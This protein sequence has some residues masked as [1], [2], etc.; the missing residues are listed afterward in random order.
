MTLNSKLLVAVCVVLLGASHA[1][2]STV[3]DVD[4]TDGPDTITGTITTDG[5]TGNLTIGNIQGWN[6]TMSDT[7]GDSAT[8]M[9]SNSTLTSS[10]GNAFLSATATTLSLNYPSPPA[11]DESLLRLTMMSGLT[12]FGIDDV[13][14]PEV[15]FAYS[16][17]SP[18]LFG[19]AT[20]DVFGVAATPLPS[21]LPLLLSGLGLLGLFGWYRKRKVLPALATG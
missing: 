21:A 4:F 11:V 15:E 6:L 13:I 18:Q 20:G 10:S 9:N 3:Y 8:F 12:A 19:A 14:T 7:S 16:G 17:S 5:T 2:A 1:K